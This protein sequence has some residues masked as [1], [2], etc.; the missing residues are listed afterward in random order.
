MEAGSRPLEDGFNGMNREGN[1]RQ[2]L[3]STDKIDRLSL[4]PDAI[5][6]DILSVIPIES[7]AATSILSRR[8][9][10][11]WTQVTHLVFDLYHLQSSIGCYNWTEP[12]FRIVDHILLQLTASKIHSFCLKFPY[13]STF[14]NDMQ[15]S[16]GDSFESWMS[17][18]CGRHPQRIEVTASFGSYIPLPICVFECRS[19]VELT[20]RGALVIAVPDCAPV[21]LPNL[22]KFS[23]H[24]DVLAID[25]LTR[26]FKSSLLLEELTITGHYIEGV[27]CFDLSALNLKRLVVEIVEETLKGIKFVINLA[28]LEIISLKALTVDSVH[29]V[30]HSSALN[31]AEICIESGLFGE[32]DYV[33]NTVELAKLIS[34]VKSLCLNISTISALNDL[35]GDNPQPPLENL[36]DLSIKSGMVN[37][38]NGSWNDVLLFLRCSPNLQALDIAFET[39]TDMITWALPPDFAPPLCLTRLKRIKIKDLRVDEDDDIKMMA[40]ILSNSVAL[41]VLSVYVSVTTTM[42]GMWDEY[43]LCETLFHLDRSSLTCEIQFFGQHITSSSK[44]FNNTIPH[45]QIFRL[46]NLVIS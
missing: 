34:N 17:T 44:G 41:E 10:Y 2:I 15:E 26:L 37:A 23:C 27:C 20:L 31:S 25:L 33:R 5:L 8:W 1:K 46:V 42:D 6:V 38:D 36:T 19:V 11:L 32:D 4:L 13:G 35:D 14:T 7:A 18:I 9:Q 43:K 30:E 22:K 21:C 40:Y 3:E 29:F 45:C 28:K 16:Y 39:H 24:L 12:F